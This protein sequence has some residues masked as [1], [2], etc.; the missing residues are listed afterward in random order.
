MLANT[1]F[2][3]EYPPITAEPDD[4]MSLL[5]PEASTIFLN[6]RDQEI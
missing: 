1:L 3:V 4:A 6:L 5:W 2:I